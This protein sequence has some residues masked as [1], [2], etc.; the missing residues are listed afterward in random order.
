MARVTKRKLKPRPPNPGKASLS[1]VGRASLHEH[2]ASELRRSIINGQLAPGSLLNEADLCAAMGLSRT[3]LRE[4]LK[5]LA[6]EHLVQLRSNRSAIVAPL[7]EDEVGNLFQVVSGVERLGA[8]LAAQSMSEGDLRKLRELQVKMEE[9][10]DSQNLPEY[11]AI[12]HSVHAFI[13]ACARNPVLTATHDWL[14]SRVERARFFALGSQSR[15]DESVREHR[16]ILEALMRRDGESA[17][18]LLSHHVLRTGN[19]VVETV[20]RTNAEEVS[21][22]ALQDVEYEQRPAP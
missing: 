19:V 22:P 6:T 11:F 20:A 12:N 10:H 18:K 21:E 15:W 1:R 3:P 7:D 9:L 16:A 8:E 5:L 14:L 13:V 4:A 17:G 2:A